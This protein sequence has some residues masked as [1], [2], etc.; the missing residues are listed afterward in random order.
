MKKLYQLFIGL[1][2]CMLARSAYPL[3]C[4]S[5]GS[6]GSES[7]WFRPGGMF[8]ETIKKQ[9]MHRSEAVVPWI[10]SGGVSEENIIEAAG[11][12]VEYI[13]QLPA[14]T[15]LSFIVHSN[16]GNVCAYA[17]MMLAS[18]YVKQ[19]PVASF[20]ETP[21]HGIS[22]ESI[23]HENNEEELPPFLKL[24]FLHPTVTKN[25]TQHME[26]HP[27]TERILKSTIS[28]LRSLLATSMRPHRAPNNYPI[29]LICCMGTPIN[30][31]IFDID[32]RV[33]K[34]VINIYSTADFVQSLVGSQLIPEHERRANVQAR[35]HDISLNPETI[36][37]CHKKIHHVTIGKWILQLPEFLADTNDKAAPHQLKSGFIT[38][39]ADKEPE[40][41]FATYSELVA[42]VSKE[43]NASPPSSAEDEPIDEDDPDWELF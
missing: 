12:L 39:F 19:Q 3:I 41:K 1:L 28:R 37:P 24:P 7:S 33:V 2:C 4:I 20:N 9:A 18:L 32:M 6:F 34:Q 23:I 15:P 11:A 8:Y 27:N 31:H 22:E 40:I 29:A 38:F 43:T 42:S 14:S 21:P 35:I 25:L 36:N 13:L 10:W 30:T 16:G 26:M 5:H 17:T